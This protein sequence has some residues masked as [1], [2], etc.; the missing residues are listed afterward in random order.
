V[1]DQQFLPVLGTAGGPPAS[2]V[3]PAA[4]SGPS[5]KGSAKKVWWQLE[6]RV[7][8]NRCHGTLE[9]LVAAVQQFFTEL[10]PAA[11]LRRAT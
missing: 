8:A 6:R 4:K 1:T 2:G 9:A 7:A 3:W 11:A 10:T 5:R